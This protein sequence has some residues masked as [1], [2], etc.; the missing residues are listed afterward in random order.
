MRSDRMSSGITMRKSLFVY[1]TAETDCH[2]RRR[3]EGTF[4]IL[5]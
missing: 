4:L 3:E 2:G 5:A 1:M